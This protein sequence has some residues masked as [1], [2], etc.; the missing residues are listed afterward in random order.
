MFGEPAW[1]MLLVLYARG[2][3][4]RLTVGRL[5]QLSGTR[6]TTALRWLEFLIREELV[7]RRPNLRDAR[8]ELIELT[9]KGRS[10]MKEY[11]SDTLGFGR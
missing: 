8:S 11:L 6:P 7:F 2:D 4:T 3:E 5:A 10:K 1:D 9:E